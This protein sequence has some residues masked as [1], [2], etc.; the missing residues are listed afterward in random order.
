MN[1][2]SG[3]DVNHVAVEKMD[4]RDVG[5]MKHVRFRI[6]QVSVCLKMNRRLK[7]YNIVEKDVVNCQ[8]TGM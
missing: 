8:H 6:N 7:T 3:K 1:P 2:V 5:C 4:V